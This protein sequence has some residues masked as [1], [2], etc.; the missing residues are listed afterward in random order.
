MCTLKNFLPQGAVTSPYL[1]NLV[2]YEFDKEII[3]Y[4]STYDVT[5][6]RY[7]D[8]LVFSSNIEDLLKEVYDFLNEKLKEIGFNLNDK[9]TKFMSSNNRQIITGIVI[10]SG[11]THIKES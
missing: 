6:S 1:S 3:S 9:K 8:D 4:C 11:S 2:L 10:N 5:Y 7:A